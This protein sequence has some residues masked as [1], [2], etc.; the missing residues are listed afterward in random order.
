MKDTLIFVGSR[1]WGSEVSNSSNNNY[2]SV[3]LI[4]NNNYITFLDFH[5]LTHFILCVMTKN[6]SYVSGNLYLILAVHW[7][8]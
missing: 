1:N 3:R 6:V 4:N 5:S 8:T 7:S 2:V